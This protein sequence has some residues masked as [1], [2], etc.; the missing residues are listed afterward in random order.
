MALLFQESASL[1]EIFLSGIFGI[2][3]RNGAPVARE[4][5]S[6]MCREMASW[7]RDGGGILCDGPIGMGLVLTFNTPEARLERL[8]SNDFPG[9]IAFTAAGRVD[10]RAE[11]AS[12]L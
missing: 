2:F 8:P 7:G 10:N 3:N 6:M 1:K 5:L 11:L 12:S 4:S 9:G